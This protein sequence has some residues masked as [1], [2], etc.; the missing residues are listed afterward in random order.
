MVMKTQSNIKVKGR[1]ERFAQK[2]ATRISQEIPTPDNAYIAERCLLH[3]YDQ[4]ELARKRRFSDVVFL[5]LRG[6]LPG[7]PQS[8]LFETLLVG[9][10]HPGPRHAATR[11][12]INAGAGKS[13]GAHILPIALSVL[14]GAHLGGEEVEASMRFIRQNRRQ[15]PQAV[16]EACVA[17]AE[18]P[19]E[20]D[21][22]IAPGFGR[23]FGGI[24]RMPQ[25]LAD[26]LLAREGAGKALRST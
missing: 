25:R 23:R 13:K 11:A 6:E 4:L 22:H 14:G 18:A 15:A 19:V 7:A 21:V 8:E 17:R 5:L 10:C 1:D 9:L 2:L 3:G 24:D 20:G 16:A 26:L 12:A